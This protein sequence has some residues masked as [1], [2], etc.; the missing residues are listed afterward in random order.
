[1]AFRDISFYSNVS[2]A[3]FSS[4]LA[5]FMSLACASAIPCSIL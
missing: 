4:L 2:C 3:V 1:M 5:L